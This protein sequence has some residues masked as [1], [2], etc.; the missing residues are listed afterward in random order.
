M[1]IIKSLLLKVGQKT[2]QHTAVQL[3]GNRIDKLCDISGQKS[4]IQVGNNVNFVYMRP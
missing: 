3:I 2:F 1:R 4:A